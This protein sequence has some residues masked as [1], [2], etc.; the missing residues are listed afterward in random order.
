MAA[1]KGSSEEEDRKTWLNKAQ[2][3]KAVRGQLGESEP[4]SAFMRRMKRSAGLSKAGRLRLVEQALLLMEMT[5]V[6]LP[7]KRAIHAIDPIRR[8]ELLRFTLEEMSEQDLPSEMQFH[9]EMQLIFTS[10]RDLHTNYLLPEPFNQKTA[11][12]PFLVEEYFDRKGGEP[13]FL[14]SHVPEWF[15]H[16]TFKKGV[17]VLFWNG[18][19]INRAIE[20][21]GENQAGSNLEAR[22]ACGLDALTIR[23]LIR[24]LPPDEEWVVIIYRSPSGP[25]RITFDWKVFTPEL[26]DLTGPGAGRKQAQA[27]GL[28][29]KKAA[30]NEVRKV[31]FA[32]H[33]LETGK[34]AAVREQ[35]GSTS[36]AAR[37][38][39]GV[40]PTRLPGTFRAWSVNT[41]YGRF[42]YIRI[43]TFQTANSLAGITRFV[44]EFRRLIKALPQDGL[45]I[46]VRGNGGGMINAG[47]ELLQLLTPRQIKP[48]LFEMI[49]TPLNRKI[50][51][52]KGLRPWGNSLKEA[53]IT[54]AS[55]SHG[56]PLTSEK[57]CND[58]GQTYYGPV[59]LII[60]ALCYS[61]T[62][63]FTAG[64]QD[65]EIGAIL[66]TSGNTG[67]GGANVCEH[68]F[69]R[70]A[71]NK[72]STSPFKPLP[73]GAGMR[74]AFRRSIRVGERVGTA[75]R[76]LEELGVVPELRHY[77]TRNDLLHDN[78]DLITQ[79]A[80]I[81]ASKK[82]YRLSAK[83]YHEPDGTLTVTAETENISRVDLYVDDCPIGPRRVVQGK[84]RFE[85]VRPILH[86]SR[87]GRVLVLKGFSG[88]KLVAALK[89]KPF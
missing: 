56:F 43:F 15:R 87:S 72:S 59:V 70:Q 57:S 84:T 74:V 29:V 5:Y 61:T 9:N 53:V 65:H 18:V 2:M 83:A 63:M 39:K 67:A 75:G 1:R 64:F 14:V 62:D 54:G 20:I 10:A 31:L 81:L 13:K 16:S 24:S 69:L 77:M 21:N 48:E 23:P 44:K 47:E 76:P 11:Y 86:G 34:R 36:E 4:L 60:D 12:L 27:L 78:E 25:K 17:Q 42:A 79:A 55:Y 58:I 88:N 46:D 8:L 6:H 35:T 41:R 33:T 19:P 82:A 52:L 26:G 85:R 38:W 51:R 68:T 45:I 30:I 40:E 50:S 89:K 22:F 32:P 80:E 73:N 3:H 71:L 37:D 28:D 49:N 7:L 66:G